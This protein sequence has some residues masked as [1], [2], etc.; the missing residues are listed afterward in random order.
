MPSSAR[1]PAGS[2]QLLAGPRGPGGRPEPVE[3]VHRAL[4]VCARVGPLAVPAQVL[5]EQHVRPGLLEWLAGQ[6]M[7]SQSG[8]VVI[9][10]LLAAGD[11]C[12]CAL[13]QRGRQR[14]AHRGE[15]GMELGVPPGRLGVVPGA[16]Q[17][18]NEVHSSRK[19]GV[20]QPTPEEPHVR[21]RRE[22]R[23]GVAEIPLAKGAQPERAIQGGKA[24]SVGTARPDL[25]QT[26]GVDLEHFVLPTQRRELDRQRRHPQPGLGESGGLGPR[27][28][29]AQVGPRG[30]PVAS[31]PGPPPLDA[32][33]AG[34]QLRVLAGAFGCHQQA[35]G[36]PGADVE[37]DVVEPDDRH[38]HRKLH[39]PRVQRWP[40]P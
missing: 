14:V 4:Q 37:K 27:P 11:Q 28:T 20:A 13:V 12:G 33:Q 30:R 21:C 18:L 25:T 16:H 19:D 40:M 10:G 5:P 15:Q 36:G 31:S 17:C 6:G 32:V 39:G 8:P 29:R 3:G 9:L 2:A 24:P 7:C 23:H 22:P 38:Q 35:V 34:D 1:L 26:S